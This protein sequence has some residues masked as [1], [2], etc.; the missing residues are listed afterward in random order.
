MPSNCSV[1][2]TNPRSITVSAGQTVSVSFEVT[3]EPL[4]GA[5]E[6]TA[7]TVGGEIDTDGYTVDLAGVTTRPI[8]ANGA[9]TFPDVPTGTHSLELVDV[10]P[11]CTVTS[12]NPAPSTVVAGETAS[13]M[14]DVTC[15]SGAPVAIEDRYVTFEA[16]ALEIAAPGLRGNDLDLDGDD[17][18]GCLLRVHHRLDPG[19]GSPLPVTAPWRVPSSP[20]SGPWRIRPVRAPRPHVPSPVAN[21][22]STRSFVVRARASWSAD[23][24]SPAEA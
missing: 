15:L 23:S 21:V 10:A 19:A 17:G 8:D 12:P 6:V 9:V 14:F 13:V 5:I 24:A 3:C 2:G 18:L 7:T 11:N 20:R 16:T 4:T 22:P 1:A